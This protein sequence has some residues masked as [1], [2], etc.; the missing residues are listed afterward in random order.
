[1]SAIAEGR[2]RRAIDVV[3][4]DREAG[5]QGRVRQDRLA[6]GDDLAVRLDDDVE[7]AF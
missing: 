3:A 6:G 7:T 5:L 4:G 2:I 1:V